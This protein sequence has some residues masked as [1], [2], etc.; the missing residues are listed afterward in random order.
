MTNEYFLKK[1][2][3]TEEVL[4]TND[5][6]WVPLH[7]PRI[8]D[9][10]AEEFYDNFFD[11]NAPSGFDKFLLERENWDIKKDQWEQNGLT[12]EQKIHSV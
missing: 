5:K 6:E 9:I 10:N 8:L 7:E 1:L 3:E 12:A 4:E 11:D 2:L